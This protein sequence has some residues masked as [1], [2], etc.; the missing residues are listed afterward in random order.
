M[1]TQLQLISIIIIIPRI[2][3]VPLKQHSLKNYVSE[4]VSSVSIV[5]WRFDVTFA[6]PGTLVLPTLKIKCKRTRFIS[7]HLPYGEMFCPYLQREVSETAC[8]LHNPH[9][10]GTAFQKPPQNTSLSMLQLHQLPNYVM[11]TFLLQC[12]VYIRW[13]SW[14]ERNLRVRVTA[15]TQEWLTPYH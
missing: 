10:T 4:T 15:R 1:T 3:T 2:S 8:Y 11:L 7:T 9:K 14:W 13:N 6:R 5:R 12:A